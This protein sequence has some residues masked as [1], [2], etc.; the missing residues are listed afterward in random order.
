[1]TDHL[2][3]TRLSYDTVAAD[4]ELLLREEMAKNPFD[5]SVLGVFAELVLGSGGGPVADLG[6]GPGRIT[7]H[8]A[9]LGLDVF[10]IDLSPE[11]VTVARWAHPGLRFD[12]GT[13]TALD[14]ADGSLAGAVAWYSTVHTPPAELPVLLGEF[15]RVL[16]PGGL[17]QMAFKVGEE[18]YHLSHAYG[19]DLDLDVY[20]YPTD[21][22]AELLKDAGFVE[23]ARLER[24]AGP[25]ENTPQGYLLARKP[26]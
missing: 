17:L 13:M 8:L 3:T 4:Y 1:M 2:H 5:R 6:C 22:I 10:G 23:S 14:L 18:S 20:R 12:V 15:H 7:G 26:A 19:H 11:M 21:L 9:S 25:K 16:A 24:E